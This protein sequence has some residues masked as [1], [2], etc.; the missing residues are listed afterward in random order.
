MPHYSERGVNFQNPDQNQG[1][2]N[3]KHSLAITPHAKLLGA[4]FRKP[5]YPVPPEREQEIID[6]VS[7]K[8]KT[9]TAREQRVLTLRFGLHDGIVYTLNEVAREY[10]VRRSRICQIQQQTLRRLRHP[11]R[12]KE[13]R[14]YLSLPINSFGREIFGA[15]FMKD[16]PMLDFDPRSLSDSTYQELREDAITV[17]GLDDDLL[18]LRYLLRADLGKH[19]L[20]EVARAEITERLEIVKL[21]RSQTVAPILEAF[22]NLGTSP[23]HPQ[24]S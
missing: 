6:E 11:S 21:A 4:I 9:L 3:L 19:S 2:P 20:S 17:Y 14:Q 15:V 24:E 18:E 23:N 7:E 13:L 16:L 5:Q 12:S 1:E 10:D 22:M 8:L